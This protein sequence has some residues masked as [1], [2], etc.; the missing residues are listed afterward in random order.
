[1]SFVLRPYQEFAI[2]AVKN[3]IKYKPETNG[4]VKAPGGSGKSILIAKT[5]EFCFDAGKRVIILARN[6]KLLTQNRAK[7]SPQYQEHIGIFCAG[8]GEKNLG[9]P[10]TIASIQSIHGYGKEITAD[11]ILIDEVQNLHSDEDSDTQY[12]KFIKDL[13]SPQIIGYTATDFRSGSGKL[14]FG[15]MICDIPIQALIDGGWLIP[16]NNKVTGNINLSEVQ[17]LRGEYNGQQLED[18]YLEPELL[19]KSIEALQKYAGDD[20][21][22]VVIFTQSR[23]HGKVLQDAMFD[24]NLFDSVY[25]DGDTPKDELAIILKNFEDR[26]FKYLIN[27]ALLIEGWD[28]PSIDCIAIFTSTTSRGKFEQIIYRGTRPAPHLNKTSFKVIDLG[29]NFQLHGPLGKP[30]KEK[31]KKETK[32]EI[33]KIC[34]TCECWYPGANIKECKECGYIF[35]PAESHKV[36]HHYEADTKSK[37]IYN[38]DIETYDITGVSYKE[39][40]SKKSGSISLRVDY[41]SPGCNKYGS[42]SAYY[43]PHHAKDFVRGKAWKFFK[44]AGH[45]LTSPVESYSMDDLLF[46]CLLLK[47]PKQI[48]VDYGKEFPEIKQVIYD[49]HRKEYPES[50]DTLLDSDIIE[51]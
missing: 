45:E 6:E 32:Q 24:N 46:K 35:P 47:Q 37:T 14:T 21:F 12:W 2:D 18:I 28:C 50:I 38:G 7:F 22:S 16:P 10:I 40:T 48:V 51:F 5:A 20:I 33:G 11:I 4:Y 31:S 41:H 8:I 49:E 36:N 1:M 29:G 13:G 15:D 25:V 19:A 43:Q 23:K 17:I 39:H 34:P 42:V 27:V 26:K 44:D 9:K 30:Y 3:W